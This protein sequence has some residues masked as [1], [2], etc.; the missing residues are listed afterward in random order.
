M[1]AIVLNEIR[2]G[3]YLDSV[4]LMRLSRTIAGMYGVEE[5]ALMMGTPSN[6]EILADAGL[7]AEA[8]PAAGGG[9]LVIGIRASTDEAA[10]AALAEAVSQLDKPAA[11]GGDGAEWRPRTLR[12]ALTAMPGAN[13]ALISVPGDFAAA[14]ARKAIRR[15]LH[16]MVFSDN[17]SLADE[18]ALKREARELGRLVMGP[19]CGTAIINGVP[20][21]FANAVPRGEVGLVGASGTGTQEVSCLIAQYG[22]GISHAIGVG[23]RDL[24]SEVGGI[25]TL[26]ALDALDADPMTKRIVLISKPPP[27]DVAVKV[28]ARIADSGKPAIICLIGAGQM[29]MPANA[30]QVFTLKAA[31]R[32]ALGLDDGETPTPGRTIVAAPRSGLI[33]GLFSGGTLC[34]EAQ[35]LFRAAGQA[36]CSNV[37]IP[38]VPELSRA[39]GGHSMI[40][41]GDDKY[42]RGKPHPMIDPSVRDQPIIEALAQSEVAAIL[43]DVVIGYGAHDDP[44]DHLTGILAAHARPGGPAVIASVTGTEEDPQCRSAQIAKL[45]AAGVFVA[46]TNADAV[47]WALGTIRPE[48]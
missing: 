42:T 8:G 36:V 23:G 35:V 7:L 10:R 9:D 11:R 45:E 31:A 32:A 25:S 38:G 41:L 26:M 3:F 40:D 27:D 12:S 48:R 13:L 34:A 20:L 33:Q 1:S 29:A 2:K 14:E 43:V 18:V 4:A 5:A 46:P 30:T 37:P 6:R 16:A 19:D 24:K 44:A 47:T 21:A 22:G 17:V 39:N 28:L 15:G